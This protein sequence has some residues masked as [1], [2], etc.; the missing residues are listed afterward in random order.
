LVREAGVN[1]V[2]NAAVVV[3]ARDL[4]LAPVITSDPAD[5]RKLDP[6]LPLIVI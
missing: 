3:C 1:D 4:G 6:V 5:L 2:V